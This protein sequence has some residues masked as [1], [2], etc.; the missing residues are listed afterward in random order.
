MPDTVDY[1][2]EL[3]EALANV[4]QRIQI[5][6]I[7]LRRKH[8]HDE[9]KEFVNNHYR[10]YDDLV[11][12][13]QLDALIITGAPKE[14]CEFEDICYWDELREIIGLAMDSRMHTLGICWGALAIGKVL[15]IG[16][17]L[18]DEKFFGVYEID[19]VSNL[20]SKENEPT[21]DVFVQFS[22]Q[23]HFNV[24]DVNK[25]LEGN[26]ICVIGNNTTL[27]YP[28]LQTKDRRHFLCLGH[29]EYKLNRLVKEWRRDE[30][31]N[32]GIKPPVGLDSFNVENKVRKTSDWFFDLWVRQ[33]G[34]LT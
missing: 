25:Q 8:Y 26:E 18:L 33:I 30:N 6:W 11:T 16:K 27:P 10:F 1:G 23:A 5:H 34:L 19:N 9:A 12:N 32:L 15:G 29:P 2:Q 31:K 24:E 13:G 21:D 7:K 17:T 14:L 22:I 20:G 28:L 3:I 4:S